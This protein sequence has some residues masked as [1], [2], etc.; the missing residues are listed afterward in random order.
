[1]A[2]EFAQVFIGKQRI[3]E[4]F[5]EM[6]DTAGLDRW[7]RMEDGGQRTVEKIA[8]KKSLEIIKKADLVLLVLDKSGE[9]EQLDEKIVDR[10]SGKKVIT[11]LNKADLPAKLNIFKLPKQLR[12]CITISAKTGEGIENQISR[13]SQVLGVADF[14][15]QS[16][17]CFTNRQEKIISKITGAKSKQQI[18]KLITELLNG[19][20]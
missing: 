17:V 13:I 2:V 18:I 10:I 19:R 9:I 11:V 6:I 5:C 16:T 3:D 4:L 7:R 1:M 12:N 20:L 14:D 8:Q 15:L